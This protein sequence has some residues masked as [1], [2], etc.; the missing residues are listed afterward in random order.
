M[1]LEDF[2]FYGDDR[3]RNRCPQ[4]LG[5]LLTELDGMESNDGVVVVA[6]T[7][8]V[9]ALEP[10]L[11][12]RPS[13]FDMVLEIGLPGA[14]QRERILGQALAAAT[15]CPA[16]IRHAASAAERASGAQLRE[17]AVLALQRAIMDGR[18]NEDGRA[19]VD[20]GALTQAIQRVMGHRKQV[21]GFGHGGGNN[22][23][24]RIRAG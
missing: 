19:V 13:R 22:R 9:A 11:V 17:I 14:P 3:K 18:V 1:F 2:D 7:N 15:V 8:D 6:T 20:A 10:A 21:V 23:E 4:V 12:D 16:T 24:C 5:E